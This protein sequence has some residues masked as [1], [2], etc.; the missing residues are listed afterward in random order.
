MAEHSGRIESHLG[1]V[2]RGLGATPEK[3]A[4]LE[5]RAKEAE[6]LSRPDPKSK[7]SDVLSKGR[8]A[9]A[10][11]EL[12]D[13]EIDERPKKGPRPGLLHPAQREAFGLDAGKK[14]KVVIKG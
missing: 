9:S 14:S 4:E 6:R 1:L 7:F 5:T 2:G 10:D 11:A 3:I 12:A 13:A 8:P